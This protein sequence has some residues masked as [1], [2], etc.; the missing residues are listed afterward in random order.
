MVP[1]ISEDFS[2]QETEI[3]HFCL[4]SLDNRGYL[5]ETQEDIAAYFKT[6]TETIDRILEELKSLDPAGVCAFNLEECL[7]L[8]LERK[9]ML[10]PVMESLID[11]HLDMVAKNQIPAIARAPSFF[12]GS[13]RLLPDH[14]ILKSKTRSI[15]QQP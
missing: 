12:R 11:N 9:K 10:T 7:K 2:E 14:Q 8:Q 6:D 15:L 13:S 3:I 4:D 1:L 5:T